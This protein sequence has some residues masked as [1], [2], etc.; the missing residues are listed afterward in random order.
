MADAVTAQDAATPEVFVT[1][2]GETSADPGTKLALENLRL[3]KARTAKESRPAHLDPEGNWGE[4]SSWM[5]LSIRLEKPTYKV[6]ESVNATIIVRNLDQKPREYMVLLPLDLGFGLSLF[7]SG[8]P[9]P[10]PTKSEARESNAFGKRLSRLIT[11]GRSFGLSP[12]EQR[13]HEMCLNWFY[14]LTQ[15]GSYQIMA[16]RE[17]DDPDTGGKS[18]IS[19]KSAAFE[20]VSGNSSDIRTNVPSIGFQGSPVMPTTEARQ[21]GAAPV[22]SFHSKTGLLQTSE[23]NTAPR[24]VAAPSLAEAGST[25]SRAEKGWTWGILF[26]A[27]AAF[28]G[29]IVWVLRRRGRGS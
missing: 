22:T 13:K 3:Q 20:I 25:S 6:G 15:P 10:V 27:I 9:E 24:P 17:I 16:L 2:D 28:V 26:A 1:D 29:S 4:P 11:G 8:K 19:T 23:A 21:T 14:D 12:K 18:L 7:A 5:Q